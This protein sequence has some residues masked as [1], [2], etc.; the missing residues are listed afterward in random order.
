MT[1]AALIAAFSLFTL[2]IALVAALLKEHHDEH[3]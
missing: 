2:G 3:R 1:T